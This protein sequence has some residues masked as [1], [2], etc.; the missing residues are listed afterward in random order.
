MVDVMPFFYWG[1]KEHST[2]MGPS[3]GMKLALIRARTPKTPGPRGAGPMKARIFR[4]CH[5]ETS[6]AIENDPY[7]DDFPSQNACD[8]Q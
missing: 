1:A 7:V 4:E 2:W 8:F 5:S 6:I 3:L